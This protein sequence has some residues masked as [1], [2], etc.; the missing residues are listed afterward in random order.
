VVIQSGHVLLVKRGAEPGKGLWALPGGFVNQSER[1]RDAAIRELIEENG[2]SLADGKKGQ[3]ITRS[4]LDGSIVDKEIFDDP[5]RSERGRTVTV[6]YLFRLNDTK[7]LPKVK[8]QNVPA[9][10][11][12]GKDIVETEDAR[13][14][15]L[16]DALSR[17]DW[18][19]EDHLSILE[20]AASV[21][22][23]S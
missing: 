6:G 4:M 12:N 22:D 19:F 3:E 9:Y 17:T 7:P 1:I 23:K 13:W 5:A 16:E 8:G 14:V 15:P 11:A 10:E 18:W 20:W 2:I 21:K